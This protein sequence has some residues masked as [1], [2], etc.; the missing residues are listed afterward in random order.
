MCRHVSLS[1]DSILVLSLLS[2]DLYM[3]HRYSL[4]VANYLK[5]IFFRCEQPIVD[6]YGFYNTLKDCSGSLHVWRFC[7]EVITILGSSNIV[8][9]LRIDPTGIMP[10]PADGSGANIHQAHSNVRIKKQKT[11]WL[12]SFKLKMINEKRRKSFSFLLQDKRGTT[13]CCLTFF[14]S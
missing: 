4:L 3:F 12:L 9:V 13:D 6:I 8:P 10:I 5:R 2:E 1:V 7:H 14:P 11:N